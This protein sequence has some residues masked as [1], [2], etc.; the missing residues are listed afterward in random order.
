MLPAWD[1]LSGLIMK[2]A[3]KSLGPAER[4]IEHF[5]MKPLTEN[6]TIK[7]NIV[8]VYAFWNKAT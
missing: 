1:A 4:A 3:N 5:Q 2:F 6:V 7:D 8:L